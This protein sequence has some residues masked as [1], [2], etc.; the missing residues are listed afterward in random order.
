MFALILLCVAVLCLA[1]SSAPPP[2]AWIAIIL[3]VVALLAV[4]TGWKP[5]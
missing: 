1:V 3:T 2:Q 5:F 4:C